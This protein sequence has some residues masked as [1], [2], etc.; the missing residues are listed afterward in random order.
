MKNIGGKVDPFYPCYIDIDGHSSTLAFGWVNNFDTSNGPL[1]KADFIKYLLEK[2]ELKELFHDSKINDFGTDYF[3]YYIFIKKL[4]LFAKWYIYDKR[5][6]HYPTYVQEPFDQMISLWLGYVLEFYERYRT[7]QSIYEQV[8]YD[9]LLNDLLW[10]SKIDPHNPQIIDYNLKA[11]SDANINKVEYINEVNIFKKGK[12]IG[13][14]YKV[15]ID[16]DGNVLIKKNFKADI[17]QYFNNSL[18]FIKTYHSSDNIEGVKKELAKMFFI[19]ELIEIKYIYNDKITD[20]E[21]VDYR[22]YVNLRASVLS[23]FKTYLKYVMT[24]ESDFDF[25]SYYEDSKYAQVAKIKRSQIRGVRKLLKTI[26]G[27]L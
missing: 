3:K 24:K 1:V 14:K 8:L 12:E 20:E 26:I 21:K 19:N 27:G 5:A 11:I 6:E 16:E 10:N 13:N 25:D 22:K 15:D 9:Q 23:T 4:N 18:K 7:A 2:T 17:Q